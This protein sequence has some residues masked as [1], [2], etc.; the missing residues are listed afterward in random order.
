MRTLQIVR[1]TSDGTSLVLGD[2]NGT[3]FALRIDER[4]TGALRGDSPPDG[5]MRIT[6]PGTFDV[7]QVQAAVR[8]GLSVADVA[9]AYGLDP[10]RVARF[11]APILD[12]R[13]HV[14]AQA[15]QALTRTDSFDGRLMS[16]ETLVER[17]TPSATWDAWRRDDGRWVAKVV[18][19]TDG[20]PAI[21]SWL[22]DSA[23]RSATALDEGAA[24]LARVEDS[25]ILGVDGAS[26]PPSG[27]AALHVVST[28]TAEPIVVH[29]VAGEPTSDDET[30]TGPVP[31]VTTEQAEDPTPPDGPSD[32]AP[33]RSRRPARRREHPD[34]VRLGFGGEQ[35]DNDASTPP[36]AAA[37][38]TPTG[39]QRPA[40]PTWDEI[41]LGR[42]EA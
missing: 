42:R 27:N 21:A 18:L 39:R 7:K 2:T 10:E 17:A 40:V 9:D 38:R 3:E 15:R 22:L 34:Q 28:A 29:P 16:L 14:A 41:M 30:P 20:R 37:P 33:R 23:R 32:P 5:Q 1:T 4:L 11:A 26:R 25:P 19:D 31:V 8:G 13:A 35:S 12:E 36:R 24:G 6:E